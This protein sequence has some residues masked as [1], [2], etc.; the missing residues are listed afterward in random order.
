MK[1]ALNIRLTMFL[2]CSHF[3]STP[4]IGKWPRCRVTEVHYAVFSKKLIYW[5]MRMLYLSKVTRKH[6]ICK[7]QYILAITWLCFEARLFQEQSH[8]G[9]LV[10]YNTV[11]INYILCGDSGQ[12]KKHWSACGNQSRSEKETR[13]SESSVWLTCDCLHVM[14]EPGAGTSD[15]SEHWQSYTELCWSRSETTVTICKYL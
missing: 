15:S 9:F 1:E 5:V 7:F 12:V 13:L 3:L 10:W 11:S 2:L 6:I 14:W 4:P 8:L